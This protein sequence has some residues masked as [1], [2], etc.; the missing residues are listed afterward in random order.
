MIYEVDEI[1]EME[2]LID[3]YD[4]VKIIFNSRTD[5]R[6]AFRDFSDSIALDFNYLNTCIDSYELH[7]LVSCFTLSEQLYKNLIYAILEKNSHEN[8]YVN[9]FIDKK[10]DPEKFS[11]NVRLDLIEQELANYKSDFAFLIG[12]THPSF[13]RY[14]EMIKARHQ[15]AHANKYP[16]VFEDYAA[17]ILVLEYLVFEYQYFLNDIEFRMKMQFE[18]KAIKQEVCK[19]C[20]N[21]CTV[22][23]FRNPRIKNIRNNTRK[24][25]K[26]YKV[27]LSR[28]RLMEELLDNLVLLSEFD[29]RT[30]NIESFKNVCANLKTSLF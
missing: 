27:I 18:L 2:K 6:S 22:I 10:I 30:K 4:R 1:A 9:K 5:K 25:L 15:Y 13:K 20:E 16:F 23:N 3:T 26:K 28:I 14:D 17:V 11:P 19:T 21:D 24:F 8:E 29:F 12:K 7:L